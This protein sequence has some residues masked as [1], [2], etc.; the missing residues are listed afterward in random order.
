MKRFNVEE[1]KER[2]N[3]ILIQDKMS[4]PQ[5]ISEILRLEIAEVLSQYMNVDD[6][7]FSIHIAKDGQYEIFVKAITSRIFYSPNI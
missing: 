3:R 4:S 1:S 7:K 2:L 6:I 5:R